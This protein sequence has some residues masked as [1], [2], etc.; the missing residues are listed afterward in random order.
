MTYITLVWNS[1]FFFNSK[2]NTSLDFFKPACR[3]QTD[4]LKVE[5]A[6]LFGSERS[7]SV[8]DHSEGGT[9]EKKEEEL[10]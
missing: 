7:C 6:R 5:N 8:G 10:K 1:R 3:I 9:K 4:L 2:K